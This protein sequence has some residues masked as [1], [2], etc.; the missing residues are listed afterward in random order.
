MGS[1]DGRAVLPGGVL[2]LPAGHRIAGSALLL[3]CIL[4][5]A[6]E[7][8]TVV[9][10]ELDRIVVSP[11]DR[12]VIEG[13]SFTA[14]AT[15]L[16]ADGES[17]TGRTIVWSTSNPSVLS[18]SQTLGSEV[19][20][21]GAGAG[22][23][24]LRA[25][26]EGRTAEAQVEVLLGPSLVFTPSEISIS[27]IEGEGGAAVNVG[28]GNGGN[29]AISGLSALVSYSAANSVEWLSV[30]LNGTTVP[31]SLTLVP[32]AV[33]LTAGTHTATVRVTSPTGG[34]LASDLDVTFTVMPPPP[35]IALAT[36]AVGLGAL[37]GSSAAAISNV[38]VT[39]AGA[40]ALTGLAAAVEY[41]PGTAEG[42]LTAT[43]SSD[44]SPATLRVSAVAT[45]L[46]AG[47][48]RARVA[49]TSP[50]ARESPVFLEVT[51]RIAQ[52]RGGSP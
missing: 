30:G 3:G 37:L 10:V 23:A 42:W 9:V 8:V 50:V 25:A 31:T 24:T 21:S 20:V 46:Q 12:T 36:D 2:R 17:L 14:S 19:V 38:S 28:V 15:L 49:V 32:S 5:A 34:G 48:Y 27:G 29:G 39:N 4:V 43:L 45:G 33:G 22:T 16:G 1:L 51:F 35:V 6:C 7:T 52:A 47:T 13:E 44:T 40:G 41:L 26:A 11:T 18:L